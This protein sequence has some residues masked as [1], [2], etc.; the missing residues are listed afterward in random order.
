MNCTFSDFEYCSYFIFAPWYLS[1]FLTTKTKYAPPSRWK[2]IVFYCET[3]T[4][5]LTKRLMVGRIIGPA[6]ILSTLPIFY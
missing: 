5:R 4:E 1:G 3:P 6:I 2:I